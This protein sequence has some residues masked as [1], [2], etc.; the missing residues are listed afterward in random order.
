MRKNENRRLLR[1]NG[2]LN[3]DLLDTG[4]VTASG[5]EDLIMGG[6]DEDGVNKFG[7]FDLAELLLYDEG[8]AMDRIESL[9]GYL[10]HKWGME[11]SLP[12]A[13][14][15]STLPPQF[16]NRPEIQLPDPFY[17]SFGQAQNIQIPTNRSFSQIDVDELP[18][19]LVLDP[20]VAFS[21]E[22]QARGA[23]LRSL[24]LQPIKRVLC[25]G[26]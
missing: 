23:I 1:T 15:F 10:A 12:L 4:T 24:L 13:H 14:P 6:I 17:I 22:L 7:Q 8:L 2:N 16:E 21:L 11:T 3:F 20:S 18:P 5:E 25:P 9:E 19:G 26:V